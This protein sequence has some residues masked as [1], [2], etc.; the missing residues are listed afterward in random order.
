MA[1]ENV[2]GEVS[3]PK[4]GKATIKSG[5]HTREI[6]SGTTVGEARKQ[7]GALFKIPEGA[8]GYSGTNQLNDNDIIQDDMTIEYVKK[9]GE[10]G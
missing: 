8:A 4:S 7:F 6:A 2:Q 5:V 3:Q 9:A 10:K 1:S